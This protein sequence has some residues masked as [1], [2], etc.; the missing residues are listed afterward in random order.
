M[1]IASGGVPTG[2]GTPSHPVTSEGSRAP[3][4]AS[5]ELVPTYLSN[6]TKKLRIS[7][8]D[9]RRNHH[10]RHLT[11]QKRRWLRRRMSHTWASIAIEQ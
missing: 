5:I 10:Q 6:L 9:Q 2:A 1:G 11:Y 3:C 7:W 4:E 8:S